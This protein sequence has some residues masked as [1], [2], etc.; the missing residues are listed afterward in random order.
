[1]AV[2]LSMKISVA[3]LVSFYSCIFTCQSNNFLMRICLWIRRLW[4]CLSVYSWS[5][6]FIVLICCDVFTFQLN[7]LNR[8]NI[9]DIGNL[10]V[11]EMLYFYINL[12]QYLY[13]LIEYFR[14]YI[15]VCR[16]AMTLPIY[17]STKE[18]RENLFIS[19]HFLWFLFFF[20]IFP[21]LAQFSFS[22]Y[23]FFSFLVWK[24]RPVRN[25]DWGSLGPGARESGRGI[26]VLW[27]LLLLSLLL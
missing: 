13:L 23:F 10:I 1:M 4:H 3:F 16:R 21:F 26:L 9:Y 22:C 20:S 5:V 19:S 6:A 27:L 25:V 8:S 15:S 14:I 11:N 2:Y 7:N 12:L 24:W 18:W 17:L